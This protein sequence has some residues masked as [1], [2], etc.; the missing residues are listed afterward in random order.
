MGD[1][2]GLEDLEHDAGLGLM[3]E[4]EHELYEVAG[5]VGIGGDLV[6]REEQA[7]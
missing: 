4:V 1:L 7:G 2:I 5:H 3:Q 6:F